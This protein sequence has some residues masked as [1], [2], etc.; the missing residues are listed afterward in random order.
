[1]IIPNSKL[2]NKANNCK[3]SICENGILKTDTVHYLE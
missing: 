3:I 1:M 2:R